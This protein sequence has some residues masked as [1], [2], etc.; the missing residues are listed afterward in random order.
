MYYIRVE[1]KIHEKIEKHFN[2]KKWGPVHRGHGLGPCVKLPSLDD[3]VY[4]GYFETEPRDIH[5]KFGFL[6]VP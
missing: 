2:V 6:L 5:G 3:T 4:K 1:S